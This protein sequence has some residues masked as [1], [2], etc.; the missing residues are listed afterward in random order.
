MPPL[1]ERRRHRL[2]HLS[3]S[4]WCTF[5]VIGQEREESHQTREKK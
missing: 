4:N 5:C 2:V 3:D 1:V